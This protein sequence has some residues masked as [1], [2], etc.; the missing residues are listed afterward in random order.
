MKHRHD[1]ATWAGQNDFG[2]DASD[3]PALLGRKRR[4]S[5]RRI[6]AVTLYRYFDFSGSAFLGGM[7]WSAYT[8]VVRFRRMLRFVLL[9]ISP[10]RNRLKA[11]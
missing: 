4:V 6:D 2:S 9:A 3:F 10:W 5:I 11:G 7:D 8:V 1:A